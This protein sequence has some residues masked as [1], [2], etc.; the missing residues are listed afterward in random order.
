MPVHLGNARIFGFE[1]ELKFTGNQFGDVSSLFYVTYVIFEI[2][3]VLAAKKWGT[4]VVIAAAIVMWSAV[5]IGT[6][7]VQN[8]HQTIVVRLLLGIGEAGIFPALTFL[9]ST[10]YPRES[11]GKRVAVL[12]GASALAGAFGGLIA[13]GIQ[14]MGERHGLS[15]WRWLFIVEGIISMVVGIICW[16]TLPH[17]SEKAWFLNAEE[18]RLMSDRRQR[19]IA[20]TGTDEFSWS[21]VWMAFTD[22]MVWVAGI[23]LFCAGIP[24]FGFGIFL[25]TIIRGLGYACSLGFATHLIVCRLFG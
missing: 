9:I 13:Y 21:F 15:A 4:N 10:I 11:Q 3:W 8:Y 2:P 22:S 16:L 12:F 20:Y 18:R 19:D 1:E 7:F 23:S 6:G 17:S 25:P 5:T 24:L 14:L